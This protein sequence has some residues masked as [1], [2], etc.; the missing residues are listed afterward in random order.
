M[1]FF[2]VHLQPN[3]KQ[4]EGPPN[5][6]IIVV[7][8]ATGTVVLGERMQQVFM[9]CASNQ[10]STRVLVLVCL[11]SPIEAS[12]PSFLLFI[13]LSMLPGFKCATMEWVFKA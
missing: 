7:S 8:T 11:Q 4:P 3:K 6:L 9:S 10:N 5:L 1:L 2:N 12:S 13:Q